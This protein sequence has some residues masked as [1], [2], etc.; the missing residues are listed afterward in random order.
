MGI[1]VDFNDGLM[2][3]LR[4]VSYSE[5]R[6]QSPY[7]TK[8]ID[9]PPNNNNT[10]GLQVNKRLDDTSRI[11]QMLVDRPGLKHLSNEALLKQS[12]NISKLQKGDFKKEDILPQIANTAKYVAQVAGSTLAQVPVNGTGTHFLRGFRTDTYLQDSTQASGFAQFFGAGGKEGAPL[13]LRGETII[14]DNDGSE[15]YNDLHPSEL[16]DRESKFKPEPTNKDDNREL[17]KQGKPIVGGQTVD[18]PNLI[19]GTT[20]PL[21]IPSTR[22]TTPAS[23]SLTNS[24][25]NVIDGDYDGTNSTLESGKQLQD[26]RDPDSQNEFNEGLSFTYSLDYNNT[27]V[28]KEKRVGLGDQGRYKKTNTT[29]YTSGSYTKA[30]V[31]NLADKVNLLD[32]SKDPLNGVTENRDL[33]QLE[34]QII[35]PDQG[36]YY[37]AFRAFLDNFDDSFNGSWNSNRYLGR[38]DS[39]YTYSGFERSINIGFKIAASSI[40][41]MRPLYRKVATLASVTAPTYGAN[42]RFM[43]GSIAKVTV[44]DYIY[45]QPGIIESV[46]YTWQKNYPWEISYNNPE[47]A[48]IPDNEKEKSQILPHVLDVSLSFKVIHDFLP[49]TG[50]NPF[51]TNHRPTGNKDTY[52]PLA[53]Q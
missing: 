32:V 2:D 8:D 51:I 41:E 31:D 35:T 29:S 18:F 30:D 33:I 46:Q 10:I 36:E 19:T 34:F 13:A 44:G 11:A 42:G 4:S 17:A 28:F 5:T 52:I 40:V 3:R 49:Q 9:N 48:N 37:L 25:S 15:G 24:K 23:G 53:G 14:Q 39:F 26:F 22:N 47:N 38:A 43:R 1:L 12:D 6:T 21:T 7:V 16:R 27:K 50:T 20:T 45:E